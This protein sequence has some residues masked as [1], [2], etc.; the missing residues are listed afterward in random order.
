VYEDTDKLEH[1]RF[2]L[3]VRIAE[4]FQSVRGHVDL[5]GELKVIV[6]FA[7]LERCQIEVKSLQV[8][9]EIIR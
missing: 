6:D 5:C 7:A 9:N 3:S 8:E 2:L 1:I 4:L